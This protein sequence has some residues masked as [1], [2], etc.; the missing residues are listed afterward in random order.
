[1][2]PINNLDAIQLRILDENTEN[3]E[4]THWFSGYAGSGIEGIIFDTR[5]NEQGIYI[6]AGYLK[7]NF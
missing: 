5:K 6:N 1:M 7:S 2:I 4:V 3:N